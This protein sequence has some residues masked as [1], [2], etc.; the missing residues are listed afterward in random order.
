MTHPL[1]GL[2]QMNPT[3]SA[4]MAVST[5]GPLRSF[6]S[7]RLR[8]CNARRGRRRPAGAQDGA[9]C[10][11]LR[12]RCGARSGVVPHNSLCSLRSRRSNIFGKSVHEARCA[13][14]P[15]TSAPRHPILR[16]HR[17]PP[18]AQAPGGSCRRTPKTLP[19]RC[20]RAGRSA[21]GRRRAT[22][23]SWP[24][25]QRASSTDSSTTSERRERSEQS[26]FGDG[27]G[28]RVAQ[29]SWSEAE[30]ASGARCGLPGYTSAALHCASRTSATGRKP[31]HS[32]E[33]KQ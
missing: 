15:Q 26:E 17:A 7:V 16:P 22:Q 20:A 28:D 21:R 13:R 33:R 14:Q 10:A 1:N 5:Y 8:A 12:L 3:F 9:V 4:L 31:T 25:A 18:A 29:G 6:V 2:R 23:G 24:R 32:S 19:P 30:A 11:S 27:P